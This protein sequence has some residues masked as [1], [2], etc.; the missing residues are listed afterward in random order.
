MSGKILFFLK[1]EF[2]VRGN[3]VNS[4]MIRFLPPKAKWKKNGVKDMNHYIETKESY[5]IKHQMYIS[6]KLVPS[7]SHQISLVQFCL[8]NQIEVSKFSK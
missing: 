6:I 8:L 4:L 3:F 7:S 1:K 2:D 5:Y